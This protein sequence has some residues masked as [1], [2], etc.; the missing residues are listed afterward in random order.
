MTLRN[1]L[2]SIAG[3]KRYGNPDC[4]LWIPEADDP[5]ALVCLTRFD[6]WGFSGITGH[7]L[8]KLGNIV[9][10]L[11]LP[12]S[13]SL[14]AFRP[15]CWQIEYLYSPHRCLPIGENGKYSKELIGD[16]DNIDWVWKSGDELF[17]SKSQSK[18]RKMGNLDSRS[19]RLY[20]KV[21]RSCG[22][23][24]ELSRYKRGY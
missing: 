2:A 7:V 19:L 11:Q 23:E 5:E 14:F 6:L 12:T 20:T 15:D 8:P 13:L 10:V 17:Q 1:R 18:P 21:K 22:K 9:P 3:K 4:K 16:N 24:G